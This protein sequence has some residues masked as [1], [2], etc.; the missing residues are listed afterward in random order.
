MSP[1]RFVKEESE[2]SVR[3]GHMRYQRALSRKDSFEGSKQCPAWGRRH[4]NSSSYL[5]GFDDGKSSYL[6]K[7]ALIKGGHVAAAL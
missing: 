5:L 1:E 6:V 2:R 4:N 3:P 7:V